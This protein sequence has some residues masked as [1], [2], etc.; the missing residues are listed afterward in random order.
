MRDGIDLTSPQNG[1]SLRASEIF[2]TTMVDGMYI[3]CGRSELT[4][5]KI[6]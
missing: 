6:V 1:D 3:A 4:L 5:L 2:I